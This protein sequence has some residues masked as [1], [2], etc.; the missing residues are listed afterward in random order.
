[1]KGVVLLA[2]SFLMKDVAHCLGGNEDQ[3]G[4]AATS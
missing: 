2:A 1:M 3:P 4:E